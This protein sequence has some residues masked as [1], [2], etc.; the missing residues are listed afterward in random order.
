MAERALLR[1]APL[2]LLLSLG[3]YAWTLGP[4]DGWGMIDLKVYWTLAPNLL[5]DRLYSIDMPFTADFPLPFT[6]P[7]FAALVFL[8]LSWLPWL[9]ARV[10]WQVLSLV[11]LW[12]LV[13][14]ALRLVAAKS[15][16]DWDATWSRRAALWTALALW[17]EPVRKTLDFGQ[18]N[19][20]LIAGVLAAMTATRQAVAGLGVGVAAG[21]K[22]TPAISS[23][24]FLATR[25]FAA[26]AWSAAG[27]ALT[28]VLGLLASAADSWR[29]WFELLGAADR[30]GPVGSAINQ[31][32]RGALSRSFGHDVGTSWPWLLA[33]A[34]S[35]VLV[36]FALRAATR[37][38]D[39]L[40]AVVAVQLFGLLLSPI[41]WSHHWVWVV[42]LVLWIAYG[43]ARR[44]PL[45]LSLAAAWVLVTGADLITFL[46][47]RQPSIWEI[48]RPWPLAALGWCYPLLGLITL[49]VLPRLLRAG[50]AAPRREVGP[51]LVETSE[52][53]RRAG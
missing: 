3:W 37:A 11:C 12:W 10:L 29:Y 30:V 16:Q 24:Y 22:L 5:D 40:A 9:A 47:D 20:V 48:P 23:L 26:A 41:S 50:G 33:V 21:L 31:S 32:L 25:R 19:L 43:A 35:A 6:Y 4:P 28:A 7:P 14:T 53:G 42:P 27:F 44:G 38:G 36:G 2:V 45:A 15:G 34:V 1:F 49:A 8:P 39:A 17:C 18:V 51:P 13:R 52:A 46:L